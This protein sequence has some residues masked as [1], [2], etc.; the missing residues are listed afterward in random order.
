MSLANIHDAAM[1]SQFPSR[2]ALTQWLSRA[3]GRRWTDL[4]ESYRHIRTALALCPIEGRAYI[5]LA[6]LSFLVGADEAINGAYIAQALRVRPFDGS[7]LYASA[8]AA[9]LAG[10]REQWI[11]YLKRACQSGARQQRQVLANLVAGWPDDNLPALIES[12]LGELQPD[13][14]SAN[15]LNDIC[16][17]R[18]SREQLTP[19]TRYRV[20]LAETEASKLGDVAAAARVW[21]DAR[22]LHDELGE[23]DEAARC[24]NNALQCD[25]GS[26]E[27]HYQAAICLL[28]Q[29]MFAQAESQVRWCLQRAPVNE[30]TA[31]LL[32]EAIKGRLDGRAAPPRKENLLLVDSTSH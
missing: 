29:E 31:H 18:C 10:N 13:R 24:V 19:L 7:V 3:V 23:S 2:E 6:D 17:K 27:A 15:F 14:P 30:N 22:R 11:Q 28:Q 26:Y 12:I 16:V 5:Y 21:L 32:R 9:L 20:Q 1:Q 4:D 25:P 8:N